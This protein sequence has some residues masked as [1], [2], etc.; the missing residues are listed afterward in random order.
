M[1]AILSLAVILGSTGLAVAA[2]DK[3]ADPVG[4]W[5]CRYEIGDQERT[6]TLTVKKD[7]DK[8]AGTMSWPDQKDEAIK[9]PK[10]ED[11]TLTFSIVRKFMDFEIPLDYTLTIDGDKLTGKGKADFGGQSQEFEIKGERE[12]KD[13]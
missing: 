13:Q 5:K 4:T 6:A 7:G 1:R 2:D 9:D 8:V 3:A 11:G 10:F 12:A